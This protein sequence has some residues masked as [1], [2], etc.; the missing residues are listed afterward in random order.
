[1]SI[2]HANEHL[3]IVPTHEDSAPSVS[4]TRAEPARAI[5]FSELERNP[6]S[7]LHDDADEMLAFAVS[8]AT[9]L[10]GP[11]RAAAR[12]EV[13]AKLIAVEHARIQS[14][15]GFLDERLLCK[16]IEGAAMIDKALTNAAK[17][18]CMYTRE[19]AAASCVGRRDVVVAINHADA[20]RVGTTER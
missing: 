14:L 17:R 15:T 1:M 13:L 11:E 5:T 12:I 18:L 20:V 9:S 10:V 3:T 19:H 7:L 16:D 2:A 4:R 8:T 6:L